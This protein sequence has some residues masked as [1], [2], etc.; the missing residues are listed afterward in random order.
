MVL[1][2]PAN[3]TYYT[4]QLRLIFINS[5]VAR[6]IN[7][8]SPIQLTTSISQPQ[9][10]TENG[11]TT[12][13]IPI[14][15]TSNTYF[16]N[17]TGS[18]HHWSELINGALQG[19]GIMFTASANQQL[20]AFD[21]MAGKFTGALYANS[22][23]TPPVIELDPVTSAGPVS[24]TSALDLT[25]Y[26]A[27]VTFNGV[28]PI[29]ATSG[30][31]GLW[32]LVE[33]PPAVAITPQS[34]A[35][36]S[37][38]LSPSCGNVGASVKVLGGG[39]IPNSQITITFNGKT[40]ATTTANVYGEIPLGTTFVIPSYPFGSY[41][42]T[43]TDTSSNSASANF[44][45]TPL[46]HFT[47]TA[48]G[49]GNISTQT[50][51]TAFSITITAKDSSGNTVTSYTQPS[52]LSVSTGT[53]S[54]TSTGEFTNGVWTGQVTLTQSGTSISISTTEDGKNGQSNTFGV[55][56][57]AAAR[58]VVSGFT[59]PVTAGTASSVT[60]TAYDAYGNV[61]T[62]Y[63]GT[64]KI[65]SSDSQA[66]LPANAGLT[67]GVGSFS[68]T[69][70]TAGSQSITA[71]DTVTSSITG[72]QTGITVNDGAAV[73]IA[74][75]PA[76]ASITAGNPETYTATAT[77]AYG[78]SWAVTGSV[79]WSISSG[80]GGSWSGNVYTSHTAGTFTVTG[81]VSGVQGTASL[82]VNP[83]ALY[84]F[85]FNTITSPQIAG[86]A[87]SITI[88]AE[89]SS[90]NTV[91]S[92]VG[93]NTLTVSSGTI[94]PTSTGAFVAGVWTGS[95]TLTKSGTGIS[96]STS[97]GGKSGTSGTFTVNPGAATSFVV[98]G[99]TNPVTAGTAGSVTVTAKDANGNTATGYSGTVKIT[100]SD[101]QAV[102]PA[103]ARLT[104]GVGSFSVTLKTA[105]SQSITATDTVTSSITGSQTG[106]TVN[107]A[108][109]SKF[110]FGTIGTQTAGTAFN[111]V[112]N[113][114]DAY[115]NT[116]STYT[117]NPTLT[118]SAGTISPTS[119][120]NFV[121]GTKTVSVTVTTS[122]TGVTITATVGSTTGTS[123]TFTV[124]PGSAT[125]FVVSGFPSPTTAGVA[126]AVTVT[127]KD[128]YGNTATGYAGTIKITSSDS[129]AVLPANAGLTNGVGSFS[130]TLE[131]AGSQSI[132]ATDT[133]TSS[134][135]G[136][137]TGITVNAAAASQLVFTMYPSSIVHGNTRY[138][139]TVQLQ[140]SYGNAV[141]AGTGGDT[142]SLTATFGSFYAAA[143][144]G[145]PITSVTIA[146][147]SSSANFYYYD[148]TT[149]GTTTIAA[150][151]G[152]LTQA[153]KTYTVT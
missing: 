149:T 32:T 85:I 87:F 116:V 20:Y 126:H 119:S 130:V 86:T 93:T 39:F 21:K 72:S 77:D 118:Y 67:N 52:T 90:G 30:N 14:V 105:G 113:A 150:S 76:T 124:N 151:Y 42:V 104:N 91:T 83:G 139:F 28:N 41:T 88:T 114:Q 13:G 82:T 140:D 55:N 57:G 59:N 132:T 111:V 108:S 125:S 36:T 95:V 11:I 102:L 141:T 78:N 131:T 50:A 27:V 63:A 145:N 98:S 80:A 136:A 152:T 121:S 92:Y 71:T 99:F 60:V 48:L 107:A 138:E 15:S 5:T 129:K 73:S 29:Y 117:G 44:V 3:A 37:I 147:G 10:M 143:T 12:N 109:L 2:L 46:D 94:S 53:I 24:F 69:L 70:K 35:A 26:G 62:G 127:A 74:V 33:Q 146:A 65:T 100:S 7:D 128:A 43:A 23:A 25:W 34:S 64:V 122:G 137:Q 115:G 38:N 51:G 135:T 106:I 133:V 9:A 54:P 101:S 18:A 58:F 142:V 49:G 110:A 47:V 96:I 56:A 4:Y 17:S 97:G 75:S 61:A 8:I 123:G 66:V 103:N 112:I 45:L 153:S 22:A 79:T 134:I 89:D 84:N 120:G 31:S 68:V 1:T 19:T 144:G 16:T 40:V 6:N 81:T 148:S